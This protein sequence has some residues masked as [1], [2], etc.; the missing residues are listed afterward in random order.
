MIWFYLHILR[1]IWARF[2]IIS[3]LA[4]TK[5]KYRKLKLVVIGCIFDRQK[6]N[7]TWCLKHRKMYVV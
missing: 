7:E 6:L 2:G 4:N 3:S 1:K 5:A